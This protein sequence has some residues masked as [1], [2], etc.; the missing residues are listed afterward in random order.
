MNNN[1]ILKQKQT[2]IS[3]KNRF[4]EIRKSLTLPKYLNDALIG[5]MLGDGYLYRS[6]LT[7]NTR[8][9][10]SLK[11]ANLAY[12]L[13]IYALFIHYIGSKP[14][15]LNTASSS[16]DKTYGSIRLKTLSLPVFNYYHDL[17]YFRDSNKQKW[18]KKVPENIN[19]LMSPVVLA[20]LL[21]GDG[22]YDIN[23]K[24]IRIFTNS[25]THSET[26]LLA[27]AIK[28]KLNINASVLY[29]R[30]DQYIIT[31][32]AKQISLLQEL[33]LEH[34]HPSMFYRI[35]LPNKTI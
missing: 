5:I 3:N 19:D 6:S 33:V 15:I 13:Y 31:I 25:F 35:G 27:E 11:E 8:L 22:N 7:S 21:M 4:K 30:K 29:D 23:R 34:F 16:G 10:C 2:K 28:Y 1:L 18:I 12:A 14:N 26:I 32:G 20:F 24:R 17:F 9:E